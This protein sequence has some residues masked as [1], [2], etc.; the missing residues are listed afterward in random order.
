MKPLPPKLKE[1]FGV[2]YR[3]LAVFRVGLALCLLG[4][5]IERGGDL[6]AHYTDMGVI[7]R[8]IV[9]D[10]YTNTYSLNFHA[11]SG[12][13]TYQLC[14]FIFHGIVSLSLLAGYRTRLSSFV[15]WSLVV[16]LQSHNPFV[17]HG[18]DLYFRLLLFFGMFLPLGKCFSV[19]SAL[20]SLNKPFKRKTINYRYFSAATIAMTTQ[21]AV[22]YVTSV[23][24]KSAK[25]W[26]QDY[27]STWYA[28]QLDYF[29]TPIGE[30]MLQYP[31]LLKILTWAVIKWE[32]YGTVFFFSPFFTDAC[33][34]FGA[35]G[36]FAMH[37]GFVLCMRLGFFFYVCA[38]GTLVL[39]PPSVWD[40]IFTKLRTTE[41]KSF[42][43][44]FNE[45][46]STSKLLAHLLHTFILIPET[47]VHSFITLSEGGVFS[48]LYSS[49]IDEVWLVAEDLKGN[50]YKNAKALQSVFSLSPLVKPLSF[51]PSF[52]KFPSLLLSKLHSDSLSQNIPSP[53]KPHTT[54]TAATNKNQNNISNNIKKIK[55]ITGTIVLVFLTIYII[56]W[57]MG[58]VGLPKLHS[59]VNFIGYGLHIEQSWGMFSPHP[60]K[61]HWWYII[62]VEQDDGKTFE[63]FR[64]AGLFTWEGNTPYS[65]EKPNPFHESFKNHRWFKF[66][67]IGYNNKN[68]QDLRLSFGRWLC[69]EYN[70]RHYK[71]K[72][73]YHYRVMF[74]IEDQPLEAPRNNR[75]S[76][77]LWEHISYEKKPKT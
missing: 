54:T 25:E 44:Y 32:L 1:M 27:T 50:R 69:R 22:M 70:A 26:T 46:S 10:K 74:V 37:L 18:G 8:A 43:I 77:E 36:Y 59:S 42:S 16:S 47:G 9:A 28:L 62:W 53:T 29:R 39:W 76:E 19:D 34:F 67:E 64:N 51:F 14:I 13:F 17:N 12:T 35:M 60:P 75:R 21:I 65:L 31:D 73:M 15:C 24:H 30:I 23:Q 11:I 7:N 6:S 66:F 3:S 68:R 45:N 4:D 61:A 41:R 71:E 20:K 52:F 2:D 40:F 55:K 72:R 58:N 57:N 63:L 38:V 56:S 33:R 5:L 49:K 48:D